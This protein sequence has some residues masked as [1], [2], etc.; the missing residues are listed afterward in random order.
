MFRT[1]KMNLKENLM[2]HIQI[3]SFNLF[4]LLGLRSIHSKLKSRKRTL[5]SLK[6]IKVALHWPQEQLLHEIGRN[7]G[8]IVANEGETERLRL[9]IQKQQKCIESQVRGHVD[10]MQVFLDTIQDLETLVVTKN[11]EIEQ[12]R[13]ELMKLHDALNA[14]GSGTEAPCN[15]NSSL[16]NPQNT[17]VQPLACDTPLDDSEGTSNTDLHEQLRQK[18][19]EIVSKQDD[20]SS[21]YSEIEDSKAS[22][23][24]KVQDHLEEVNVYSGRIVE[25]ENLVEILVRESEGQRLQVEI[26]QDH[27]SRESRGDDD[28]YYNM[29]KTPHGICLI[30][31][32]H[33]FFHA[34]NPDKACPDRTHPGAGVD[35]HN[36]EQTFK[37]L[38]YN[39]QVREN[40]SSEEMN[41][42][43]LDMAA[44]DHSDCDSFI[45]C[46]ITNG[47]KDVVHGA[48]SEPVNVY[49]LTEVMKLCP[50]LRGKPKMFFVQACRGE[51]ECIGVKKNEGGQEEEK[52]IQSDMGIGP[53]SNLIPQ[54]ADFFY[55]FASPTGYAAYRSR[56]YGSWYISEL[57]QVLVNNVYKHTLNSMMKKVHNRVS[58]AYT[59]DGYK[60]CPEYIDRLRFEV[61]FFRSISRRR[62]TN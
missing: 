46:I 2:M 8:E 33:K 62:Q 44:W 23:E 4:S 5:L 11:S 19:L 61:H 38:G 7:T 59:K 3:L 26:L 36:L 34:S 21:L 54:V 55:G 24:S 14:K 10:E 53:Y 9:E 40:L 29:D 30:I 43:M 27:I 12:K 37:Y 42:A 35:L 47:E 45:C 56:R 16:P 49:N 51:S 31:N 18:E 13:D 25:L 1:P 50:T 60:Q 28:D 17:Q 6:N 48:D 57:C 41:K 22:L 58:E 32:N 39:V 15:E 52:D 20:I